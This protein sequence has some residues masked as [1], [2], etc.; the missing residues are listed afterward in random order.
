M[1][2]PLAELIIMVLVADFD[3]AVGR[4]IH[5]IQERAEDGTGSDPASGAVAETSAALY[6]L[7]Y[8]ATGLTSSRIL[9]LIED[10]L[11]GR[12]DDL[13]PI[14]QYRGVVWAVDVVGADRVVRILGLDVSEAV[15]DRAL[16]D[17][18]DGFFRG[19]AEALARACQRERDW[20]AERAGHQSA[21]A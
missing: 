6:S 19:H 7:L 13:D 10:A 5:N 17:G 15:V 21:A 1:I 9:D 14:E 20:I 3:A 8:S 16:A 18:E 11:A 12:M 4:R 2:T